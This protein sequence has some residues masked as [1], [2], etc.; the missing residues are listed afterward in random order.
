MSSRSG[1]SSPESAPASTR[2]DDAAEEEAAAAA[3]RAARHAEARRRALERAGARARAAR[4]L[5]AKTGLGGG[6][7]APSPPPARVVD[8]EDRVTRWWEEEDEDA[9]DEVERSA[10]EDDAATRPEA[11]HRSSGGVVTAMRTVTAAATAPARARRPAVLPP[12]SLPTAEPRT[13]PTQIG[14]STHAK[15]KAKAT[16]KASAANTHGGVPKTLGMAMCSCCGK[17]AFSSRRAPNSTVLRR[18]GMPPPARVNVPGYDNAKKGTKR[19]TGEG[20]T[21]TRLVPCAR[22]AVVWCV[23]S[24]NNAKHRQNVAKSKRL[25]APPLLSRQFTGTAA[26][27]AR[28][29]TGR[30]TGARARGRGTGTDFFWFFLK[31]LRFV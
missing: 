22:C 14:V 8:D 2:D 6:D 28:G 1:A 29:T 26:R 11:S 3:I 5:E 18:M 25:T 13:N 10:D 23:P 21:T 31:R 9:R 24:P 4:G 27:R 15:H 12:P 16:A 19:E 30:T 17:R 7:L 20:E